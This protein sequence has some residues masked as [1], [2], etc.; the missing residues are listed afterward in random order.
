MNESESF[1]AKLRKSPH[2]VENP[3]DAQ[4][5]Q[6]MRQLWDARDDLKSRIDKAGAQLESGNTTIKQAY[7][8]LAALDARSFWRKFSDNAKV[9]KA[10]SSL[11]ENLPKAK[12]DVEA[13]EV[14]MKIVRTQLETLQKLVVTAEEKW[15]KMLN[16]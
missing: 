4:E 1:E 13:L 16:A 11:K 6:S 2:F 12:I 5:Y 9:K 10:V 7:E 8:Q 3:L 15:K 14:E